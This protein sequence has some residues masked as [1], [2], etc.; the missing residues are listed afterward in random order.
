MARAANSPGTGTEPEPPT[1]EE[2]RRFARLFR[3]RRDVVA[4]FWRSPATGREGFS[5]V[6]GNEWGPS[7]RK[8]GTMANACRGC[9]H[10]APVPLGRA[11][12]EDHVRGRHLLGIYPLLPDGTCRFLAADFDGGASGLRPFD[13]ARALAEVC[14]VLELPVLLF[15]SRSGRGCHAYLFFD[16]PVSARLARRLGLGLLE[17]AG[18]PE[19]G[20]AF[21]RFF[22]A[23]DR[24]GGRG[25][26]SLIALPFWGAAVRRGHTLPLDPEAGFLLPHAAPWAA[27]ARHS[28]VPAGRVTELLKAWRI[29]PPP[30]RTGRS[31]WTS[32]DSTGVAGALPSESRSRAFRQNPFQSQGFP[33]AAWPVPE[34]ERIA[35][36][37]PF[38]AH[39]RDDAAALSEPDW[40]VLLTISARCRDGR[41]LAHR[42]S[43]PYPRYRFSETEAKIERALT[44]TGPYR[45]TTIAR[46]NGRFCQTCPR[47]GRI[48]SPIRLGYGSPSDGF[49]AGEPL[50]VYAPS[51]PGKTRGEVGDAHPI[52]ESGRR[53]MILP[54][55]PGS[56]S[57]GMAVPGYGRRSAAK[58]DFPGSDGG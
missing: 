36:R 15:R 5:P 14:A 54:L 6:C 45:C 39:C 47:R 53:N 40:Y 35:A 56:F 19:S 26:G 3:G 41:R 25:L 13:E 55:L 16:G 51:T 42:L 10:H 21:D 34:F 17:E 18:I 32:G 12:L 52:L 38:I 46:I 8:G 11:L 29:L 1:V 22:P 23:Q 30:E 28:P 50:P 48:S 24:A 58:A 57:A 49:S 44:C 33:T 43:A 9:A 31:F 2:L 37:C 27:L 7:C 4:R 20:G